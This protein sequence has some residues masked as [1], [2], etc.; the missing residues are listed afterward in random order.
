MLKWNDVL[1]LS[2]VRFFK[3]FSAFTEQIDFS[4]DT[5]TPHRLYGDAGYQPSRRSELRFHCVQQERSSRDEDGQET[6]AEGHSTRSSTG[7]CGIE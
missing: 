2:Q 7:L 6:H 4:G 1:A 5:I 3:S